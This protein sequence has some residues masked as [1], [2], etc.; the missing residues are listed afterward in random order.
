MLKIDT[1]FSLLSDIGGK[2]IYQFASLQQNTNRG[3]FP[4]SQE[5]NGG[6]EEL[7]RLF[8]FF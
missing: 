1:P 5:K 3:T 7:V 4:S 6:E 8:F 2:K